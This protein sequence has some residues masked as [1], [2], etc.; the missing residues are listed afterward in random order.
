MRSEKHLKI[1]ILALVVSWFSSC[2][3]LSGDIVEETSTVSIDTEIVSTQDALSSKKIVRTPGTISDEK[4]KGEREL[5]VISAANAHDLELQ[6]TIYPFFPEIIHIASN[7]RVAALGD[8]AGIRVIDLD[9]GSE[10]MHL[11]ESFPIC[12]FGMDRFFQLNYDGSFLVVATKETI[13]VWQVGSGIVYE[14][15]YIE[16]HILDT[17]L[18]GADIPQLAISPDGRRLAESGIRFASSNV[19]SYFRIVDIN[20]NSIIYEWDGKTDSL[21]GQFYTFPGLGYSADGKVLQTFDPSRFKSQRNEY[22][23]SFRFWSSENWNELDPSSKTVENAFLEGEMQFSVISDDSISVFHKTNGKKIN[24]LKVDGCKW[25]APCPSE[26]SPDGS[27]IAFLMRDDPLQYK[28]ESLSTKIVVFDLSNGRMTNDIPVLLRNLDGLLVRDDGK[29]IMHDSAIPENKPKWWTH[30]G[31]FAG[32]TAIEEE[33]ISFTPQVVDYRIRNYVP[34]SGSCQI[35]LDDFTLE[36]NEEIS[37]R[38][39]KS[40]VVVSR[41]NV[42]ELIDSSSG[43]NEIIGEIDL[44][45]DETNESWQFRLLDYSWETGLGVYCLDRNYREEACTIIDFH[46]N[47]VLLEQI[48]LAGLKYSIENRTAAFINKENKSL[49][50][51]NNEINTFKKMKTYQA[52]SLTIRP[53]FLPVENELVYIVQ[54]LVEPKYKYIERIDTN[55]GKVLKRY[56]IESLKTKEITSI[57]VSRQEEIWSAADKFGNIY[58]INPEEETVIHK[59]SAAEE[60]IVDIIFT[61][62]GKSLIVMGKSGRILAF[63]V[64]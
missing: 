64:R 17:S 60:G 63:G 42:I 35:L 49:Y 25:Y 55:L 20:K 1:I 8:L 5:S 13:Q 30:T 50:L 58:V 46:N 43:K 4:S 48:N 21:H 54:S 18:C 28:R 9:D 37:F 52:I 10:L 47:E 59:I 57:S 36:C 38:N 26:F 29:I 44:S 11:K 19:E 51:F 6:K 39:E 31:Y 12:N 2:A 53:A 40:I 34:F 41:V 56:D 3:S 16:D 61:P 32:F 33:K 22:H 7:G 14:V 24:N 27:K 45:I 15:P 23:T 62:N